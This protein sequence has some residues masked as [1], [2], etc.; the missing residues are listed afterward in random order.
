MN[1]AH[2]RGEPMLEQ[3]ARGAF[4]RS[5]AELDAATRAKLRRARRTALESLEAPRR[6]VLLGRSSSWIA[7]GAVA[8]VAISFAWLIPQNGGVPQ[9]RAV[10]LASSPDVDLL[11]GKDEL[12]MLEDLD[13][14][15]WLDQQAKRDPPK[16]ANDGIG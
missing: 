11:L 6:G 14:Y 16:S 4:E 7:A 15:S 2:R 1:D 3:Q 5:V 8:A 9:Q 10:Q 13:F 12:D